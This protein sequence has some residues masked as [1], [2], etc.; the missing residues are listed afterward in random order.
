MKIMN[1]YIMDSKYW[2]SCFCQNSEFLFTDERRKLH[3]TF[4]NNRIELKID[5]K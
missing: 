5:K 3:E 4:K 1:Y 2:W